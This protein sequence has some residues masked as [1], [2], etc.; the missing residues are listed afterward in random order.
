MHLTGQHSVQDEVALLQEL[1]QRQLFAPVFILLEPSA[2]AVFCFM[3]I[4]E[5]TVLFCFS[6]SADVCLNMVQSRK[7]EL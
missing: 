7:A 4:N 3:E 1:N 6:H 5:G 2:P